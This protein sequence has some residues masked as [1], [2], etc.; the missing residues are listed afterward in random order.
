MKK[1][2]FSLLDRIRS[3]GYAFEGIK[4][5]IVE[6]HNARI[7]F[8]LS[9]FVIGLGFY[10]KISS[11]EWIAVLF[12]IGSVFSLEAIN[13]SIEHLADFVRPEKHPLIKKSKDLAAAAVL[14]AAFISMLIACIIF[15]PKIF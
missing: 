5:L 2:P 1:K 12:C 8:V 13:S 6:E 9:C 10:C 7:H 4:T 3:F 15:L 14:F 11:Y